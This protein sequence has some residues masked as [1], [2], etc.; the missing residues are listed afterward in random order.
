MGVYLGHAIGRTRVEW[1][2]LALTRFDDLA[3]HFGRTGLIEARR[4]S[5]FAY[6]LEQPKCPERDR[7]SRI[8]R[9]LE[10]NLDVTLGPKIVNFVGLQ[11]SQQPVDRRCISEVTIVEKDAPGGPLPGWVYEGTGST[12]L[13]RSRS[14]THPLHL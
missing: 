6:A 7:L 11:I 3:K 8:F 5:A 4:Y 9:D 13:Q 2:S 12:T 14:P 10:T 1:R